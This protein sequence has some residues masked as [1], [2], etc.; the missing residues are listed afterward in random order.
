MVTSQMEVNFLAAPIREDWRMVSRRTPWGGF[1]P[2]W[3]PGVWLLVPLLALLWVP[4]YAGGSPGL[5]GVPFFY[6]Y[7]LLWVLLTP[8]LMGI[9]YGLS[10]RG[11]GGE[12]R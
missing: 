3:L 11:R 6:W 2:W 9:A 10:R 8:A 4:M 1:W 5:F 12:G 7:Q